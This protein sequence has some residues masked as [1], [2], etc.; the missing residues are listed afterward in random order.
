MDGI[1]HLLLRHGLLQARGRIV[2]N[3]DVDYYDLDF[4]DAARRRL[5]EP[6]HPAIVVGSYVGKIAYA[7]ILEERFGLIRGFKPHQETEVFSTVESLLRPEAANLWQQRYA[8]MLTV[9]HDPTEVYWEELC[10]LAPA[11]E[12]MRAQFES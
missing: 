6:D 1:D 12:G 3:F 10:R 2:V 9:W 8:E 11:V 7:R 5:G 4:L